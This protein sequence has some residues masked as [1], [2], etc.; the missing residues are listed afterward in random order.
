MSVAGHS[1][2]PVTTLQRRVLL[3]AI[4]GS[5]VSFLDGTVVSVALPAIAAELG[6]EGAEGLALQQWVVDAYL[7]TLGAL[8]LVAGSVSDVYGRRRVLAAGLVGFAVASVL[9]A[10]APTGPVLVIARAL[11][12]VAG[13]LLVPSSLAL[14]V[15]TFGGEAQARAIGRWTSW[16]TAAMIVG[17]FVGGMLVDFA[18]WR[19]VFWI[20][21]PV[22]AVTLWL[23]RGVPAAEGEPGRRVDVPGAA[24]AAF[25][26]AGVV[27]GLIE[28]E[29]LGWTSPVIL[30]SVLAGAV[31]LVSFVLYQRRAADPML[32]LR[33]FEARNFAWG[34]L[35]TFAIYGALSLGGF[36]L[37]LFLQQVAG[38]SATWSG[39]AQLPTTLAMILLSAWF[40][41][42]AGRYG[43]R[44]FMTL[45]PIVAAVGFLL[46]LSMDETAFYPT[47]VL[48]GQLVFGLGLSITVAPLTAA[49][50]GAVPTHD[51]GIGSAVNN[52]V[53]RV[54]GLITVAFAG[55]ITGGVLDVASFHRAL[56]VTAI[57]LVVGGLLSLAGIRN[58][59]GVDPNQTLVK[60][61]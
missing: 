4:L 1:V 60:P 21:V 53:A 46:M 36:V 28:G 26:L 29:R 59:R 61:T 31:M 3:V 48:P 42:L 41:T 38:Y 20:N 32:P 19:W 14:I 5:F 12:G 51:A 30:V 35:A 27:F 11:Q 58:A 9:C 55:I 57:L 23:L 13:A 34:N 17:P 33:L 44:L 10:I 39:V 47:Q 37:T 8:M 52:A 56:V 2:W 49:I 45:G 40:G 25:G 22:I 15:A 50:L 24:L 16:T 6:G 7:V 43:P 54:A 18:S